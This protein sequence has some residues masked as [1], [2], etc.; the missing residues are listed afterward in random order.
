MYS[1]CRSFA[2]YLNLLLFVAIISMQ[3]V[4]RGRGWPA[5]REHHSRD[6]GWPPS[7]LVGIYPGIMWLKMSAML[8]V[9]A[10]L[11]C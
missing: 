9:L 4:R 7:E 5:E 1:L 11:C 2:F 3:V 6:P 10:L 8:V